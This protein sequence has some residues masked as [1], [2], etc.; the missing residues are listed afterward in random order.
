MAVTFGALKTRIQAEVNRPSSAYTSPIGDAIVTAIKFY[1]AKP[2][3]FTEK[4]GT[5]TLLSAAN[6]VTYP[7]DLKAITNLRILVGTTYRGKGTGF[8]PTDIKA[9]EDEWTDPTLS[10]TPAE[11]ALFNSSIY[12]NCL[13]DQ[14]YTLA[15]TYNYGDSTYPSADGDTSVWFEEGAD[16][17]RY[18][19]KAIFYRDR[20][21]AYDLA[22][23]A[24][25]E[26]EEFY[27]NLVTRTNSRDT[28]YTLS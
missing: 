13:A 9:M 19:A 28:E 1:E 5:L 25:E 21:H 12:V 11:W 27:Q 26:A 6:S 7:T 2:V 3:W 8:R 24:D 22:D 17:I 16:T 10:Q 20:L 18:K 23:A 14:N 4:K 15:I